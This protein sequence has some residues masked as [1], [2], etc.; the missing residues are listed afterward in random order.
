MRAG[1]FRNR[2]WLDQP[3]LS[4][5]DSGAN[6]VAFSPYV[7]VWAEI[8]PGSG[9]ETLVGTEI[10]AAMDTIINIRWSVRL[11]NLL[12][13]TWRVRHHSTIYNIKEPPASFSFKNYGRREIRLVC[14]TGANIGQ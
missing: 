4:Q 1:K 6:V 2:I 13:A 7:E 10:I 9:K 3:I 5:D 8:L 12:N 14:N 11:S